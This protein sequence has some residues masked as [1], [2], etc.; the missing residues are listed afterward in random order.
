MLRF[1]SK[2]LVANIETWIPR[3]KFI[4][5]R[6]FPGK[7]LQKDYI[8]KGPTYYSFATWNWSILQSSMEYVLRSKGKE[9]SK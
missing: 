4:K 9:K 7:E 2:F 5:N 1:I 8:F 3:L 6:K